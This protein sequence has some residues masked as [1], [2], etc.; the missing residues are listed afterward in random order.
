MP[1]GGYVEKGMMNPV[2]LGGILLKIQPRWGDSG[3]LPDLSVEL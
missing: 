1:R 3:W 2:A